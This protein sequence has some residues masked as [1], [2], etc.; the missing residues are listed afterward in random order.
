MISIQGN[1]AGPFKTPFLIM[2]TNPFDGKQGN[3]DCV[4][5]Q[6]KEFKFEGHSMAFGNKVLEFWDL[7]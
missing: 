3:I 7:M 5:M 1:N 2:G 4:K 6:R